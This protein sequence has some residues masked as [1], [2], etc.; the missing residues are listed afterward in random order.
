APAEAIITPAGARYEQAQLHFYLAVLAHHRG[1][2]ESLAEHLGRAMALARRYEHGDPPRCLFFFVEEAAWTLPL[3]VHALRRGVVPECADCLLGRLSRPAFDA[4]LP[5]LRDPDPLVRARAARLL[6][7]LGEGEALRP[8]AAL[9][10]DPDAGVRQAAEEAL[11][12]LLA[13]PPEPLRVQTLGGFRLRRGDREVVRWPR[14]SARDVFLLL[15]EQA[16]R[17]VPK[18][19][20]MEQLWPGSPPDKA[21]QSLRRAIAD[22]RRT[23]EPELP[24]GLPSRYVVTGDETYALHLPEGSWVDAVAFED[25]LARALALR[26]REAEEKRKALEVLEDALALYGGDYIPEAPYEDWALFRREQL[27]ERYLAGLRRLARWQFE[28]GKLEAA[29]ETARRVLAVDPWDED[30]V[31]LLM[32]AYKAQGHPAAALRV[33]ETFRERLKREIN[34]SPREEL[35]ALYNALRRP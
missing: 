9:R 25:A 11:Q 28:L 17:P 4:V 18:E 29:I 6:G 15:L 3:M 23:L 8:L 20:L 31:L 30:S 14:R 27:R 10:R 16:P 2:E 13:L 7:R 12:R 33:Y 32:R 1:D 35:T 22:L 34:L 26:P 5:L 21:A 19:R 24:A